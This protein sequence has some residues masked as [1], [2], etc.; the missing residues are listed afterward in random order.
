MLEV[1]VLLHP[2][3]GGRPTEIA[4]M[5]ITQVAQGEGDLR[6][7]AVKGWVQPMTA[8]GKLFTYGGV[9]GH[10]RVK[11]PVWSLVL[12]AITAMRT[13]RMVREDV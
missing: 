6:D 10:D 2:A 3:S 5:E 7:Y 8:R 9:D 12:K 13:V 11:E 1:K 4:N